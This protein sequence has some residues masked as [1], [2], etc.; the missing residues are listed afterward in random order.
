M[1]ILPFVK[2]FAI[3]IEH[4]LYVSSLSIR[5]IPS[6]LRSAQT[7]KCARSTRIACFQLYPSKNLEYYVDMFSKF[8]A[9]NLS[10][11]AGVNLYIIVCSE[12]TLPFLPSNPIK[13]GEHVD[14]G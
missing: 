13:P 14:S 12:P 5:A 10:M 11:C 1:E 2:Y 7:G 4:G 6:A 8:Y 3:F 9:V